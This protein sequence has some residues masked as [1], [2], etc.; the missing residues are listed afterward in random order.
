MTAPD[1]QT[2]LQGVLREAPD[3]S[4]YVRADAAVP[5]GDVMRVIGFAARGRRPAIGN[6]HGGAAVLMSSAAPE[7]TPRA[8]SAAS[9]ARSSS[10]R[11]SMPLPSAS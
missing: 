7:L 10:R 2:K 3:R 11:S 6:D 5:Y 4:V 9:S 8:S 1:L